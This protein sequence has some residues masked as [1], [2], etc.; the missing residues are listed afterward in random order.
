MCRRNHLCGGALI[1]FGFGL[2]VGMGL[3]S[4]FFCFFVG[5]SVMALGFWCL[6]KK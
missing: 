2:I 6:S 3:E 4:G 5:I 1:A